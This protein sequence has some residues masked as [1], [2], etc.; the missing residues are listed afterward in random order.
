[1][2]HDL[3]QALGI[4]PEYDRAWL[5][6]LLPNCFHCY[7]GAGKR[8]AV[9][10]SR[11][12]LADNLY[13]NYRDL[14]NL[15]H[16]WDTNFAN[17]FIP[18]LN[19]GFDTLTAYPQ[20]GSGGSNVTCDAC[21]YATSGTWSDARTKSALISEGY[22][23]LQVSGS[24]DGGI[25]AVYRTFA[26]YD[27]RTIGTGSQINNSSLFFYCYS[28]TEAN[29]GL[30]TIR[31]YSSTQAADNSFTNSDFTAYGST[32]FSSL[33]YSAI[34]TNS[35]AEFS[36]NSSGI[37]NINKSGI[38]KFCARTAG[39]VDNTTPTGNN[40]VVFRE[41]DYGSNQPYLSVNYTVA[42]KGNQTIV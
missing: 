20:S 1:M 19:A 31:I 30:A 23:Y 10:Y 9:F 12:P 34:S 36:L 18:A 24:D 11:Q 38:S 6:K 4:P 32:L 5:T 14:W 35:Y 17:K 8:V 41:T 29:S 22:G 13:K 40:R 21:I 28:K 42:A 25:Y 3:R 15:L 39:D 26:T 16:S 2:G 7:N 27:T 37:T 33:A